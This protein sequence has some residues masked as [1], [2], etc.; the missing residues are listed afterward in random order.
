[1]RLALSLCVLACLPPSTL[2]AGGQNDRSY[3]HTLEL[4]I[5]IEPGL[6]GYVSGAMQS[7]GDIAV[8]ARVSLKSDNGWFVGAAGVAGIFDNAQ[9]ISPNVVGGL[10]YS[11]ARALN[12]STAA[13]RLEVV[14]GYAAPANG[15][16]GLIAAGIYRTHE[17]TPF[18]GG[19]SDTQIV[20]GISRM[21]EQ[22]GFAVLYTTADLSG[23]D[24]APQSISAEYRLK[25][26]VTFR[27]TL[28]DRQR[29]GYSLPS[30]SDP[31]ILV[32]P[33]ATTSATQLFDFH[34]VY[35]TNYLDAIAGVTFADASVESVGGLTEAFDRFASERIFLGVRYRF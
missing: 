14:A 26:G 8:D 9:D 21:D 4:P 16:L 7:G 2:A 22:H 19:R 5:P 11:I 1:M 35:P 18:I 32:A 13:R 34:F 15:T 33:D 25:A 27:Y 6:S 17:G 30:S 23:V 10:T 29:L 20:I 12:A 28:L 3:F 31:L 24:S